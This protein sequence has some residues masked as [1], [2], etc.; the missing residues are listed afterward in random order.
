MYM[1]D[2]HVHDVNKLIYRM[3]RRLSPHHVHVC[4]KFQKKNRTCNLDI[5]KNEGMSNLEQ[6]SVHIDNSFV[7]GSL[8]LRYSFA[9]SPLKIPI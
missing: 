2:H 1:F 3:L 4:A 9:S 6:N 5:N 8:L 7:I